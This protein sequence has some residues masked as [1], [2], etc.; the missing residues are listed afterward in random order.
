M[1]IIPDKSDP[2]QSAESQAERRVRMR[3]EWDNL[4]E[5]LIADGHEKG[6]FDNLPGKGK[7]LNLKQNPYV[8]ELDL[9]HTLL[10]DNDLVPAWISERNGLLQQTAQLRE[11]MQRSWQ[12][13]RREFDLLPARRDALTISW[14]D[15]CQG[16]LA[17]IA[18]LNKHIN[19]YNLKRP[20]DNL[21]IYKL[22]LDRELARIGA[23]RLLK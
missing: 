16:W 12:R 10:K 19:T 3:Q 5:D 2:E 21:E 20:S 1:P 7:P 11:Q 23:G 8:P 17:A 13:H 14:Y 15:A 9:A 18:E 6:A 4:I 22:D